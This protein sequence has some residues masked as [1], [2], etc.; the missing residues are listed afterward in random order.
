MSTKTST[1]RN[2]KPAPSTCQKFMKMKILLQ[3][4]KSN[5]VIKELYPFKNEDKFVEFML[6]SLNTNKIHTVQDFVLRGNILNRTIVKEVLDVIN[7]HA[8]QS[9]T[10][11]LQDDARKNAFMEANIGF[12]VVPGHVDHHPEIKGVKMPQTSIKMSK[13]K[14]FMMEM[15][16]NEKK[17]N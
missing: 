12:E 16:G 7:Y 6:K 9:Y 17:M 4:I 14:H 15:N 3:S 10:R 8:V 11:S 2:K 1:M 13:K 5:E